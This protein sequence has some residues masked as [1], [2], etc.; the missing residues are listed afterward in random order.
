[1]RFRKLAA[2][3]LIA[4]TAFCFTGA[5]AHAAEGTPENQ[6]QQDV[7][8]EILT[9]QD[10]VTSLAEDGSTDGNTEVPAAED[11]AV[12]ENQQEAL[13]EVEEASDQAAEVSADEETEDSEEE[14]EAAEKAK[15]TEKAKKTEK[16]E[17]ETV[18][19]AA[20]KYTKS[21]LRLLSALVF[22]EAQGESYN[23]KLAVAIVV[24]NRV[25]SSRY[26]DTVKNVI[27][28]R[29]QFSPAR[30]GS[31]KKALAEYD[32]GRFT[33]AAEKDCI[34][35]AK[36]ALSGQTD[37]TVGSKTVDF[38]KYLSFSGSMRGY[39]YKLGNHKFK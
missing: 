10:V 12:T 6:D 22:C 20:A 3:M 31:L 21:E 4:I 8:A 7:T 23:G 30:N 39:T 19:K 14:A 2:C 33:S 11:A 18:K 34:E 15:D 1:M 28:Q 27:Y 26:P 17:K 36:A 13:T 29:Y 9:E 32:A 5:S 24:M 37:I 16:A 38:S 25:R 35:A